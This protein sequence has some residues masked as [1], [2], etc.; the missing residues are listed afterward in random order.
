MTEKVDKAR[1]LN[2]A[3]HCRQTRALGPGLRYALWVQGCHFD[4]PGC[5]AADWRV[6]RRNRLIAVETL[7]RDIMSTLEVEGLTLSGGEPMLQ[8]LA[9]R[10]LIEQVRVQRPGFTLVLY[11][12]F[13]LEELQI[14]GHPERLALL[15]QVDV[16]IDGRYQAEYN[17][18]RGLRGSSNQRVHLLTDAYR[19]PGTSYFIEPARRVELHPR[20]EDLLMVGIPPLGLDP[21]LREVLP[22]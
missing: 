8:P 14:Q 19:E 12:G 18:N 7:A 5:L 4:C 22:Q 16:L 21:A 17:D 20:P 15:A 9:C 1:T 3:A 2:L 13:T 10:R 6:R 11:T